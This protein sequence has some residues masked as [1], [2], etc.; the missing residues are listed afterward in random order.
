MYMR[1]KSYSYPATEIC[2]LEDLHRPVRES[3]TW[4]SAMSMSTK[5]RVCHLHVN[6]AEKHAVVVLRAPEYSPDYALQWAVVGVVDLH[7][8]M[9]VWLDFICDDRKKENI[10]LPNHTR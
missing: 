9:L 6:W 3:V 1:A 4:V 7:I 2:A 5:K 8:T 10:K